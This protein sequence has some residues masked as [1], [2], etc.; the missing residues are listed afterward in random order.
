MMLYACPS[1]CLIACLFLQTQEIGI[2]LA[3]A[4]QDKSFV[5]EMLVIL[6]PGCRFSSDQYL[7]KKTKQ[8]NKT[9]KKTTFATGNQNCLK[10]LFSRALTFFLD[11]HAIEYFVGKQE[12]CIQELG[13][14]C[15]TVK[16]RRK[17]RKYTDVVEGGWNCIFL[18]IFFF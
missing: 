4:Q 8:H 17:N 10:P 2:C 5:Y 16:F 12:K 9:K 18:F 7:S 11:G 3:K 6:S 1:T 13:A 14:P 15:T